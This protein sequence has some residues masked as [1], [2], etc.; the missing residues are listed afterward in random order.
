LKPE[1]SIFYPSVRCGT[2]P[3]NNE[4]LSSRNESVLVHAGFVEGKLNV[5]VIK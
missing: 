4:V 3:R 5:P 2:M 1:K